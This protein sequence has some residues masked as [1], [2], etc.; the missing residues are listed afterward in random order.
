MLLPESIATRKLPANFNQ[1]DLN[2]FPHE[3]EPVIPKTRLIQL[4]MHG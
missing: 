4:Q 2:L 3:F 1:D